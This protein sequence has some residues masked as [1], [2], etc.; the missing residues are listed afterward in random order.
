M[1]YLTLLSSVLP[2]WFA[3]YHYSISTANSLTYATATRIIVMTVVLY[4]PMPTTPHVVE[5]VAA[6]ELRATGVV[7]AG[8]VVPRTQLALPMR[9]APF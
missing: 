7:D 8:N 2:V 3:T 1:N 9:C 4:T 5:V 6:G